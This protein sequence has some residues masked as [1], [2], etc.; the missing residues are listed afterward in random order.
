MSGKAF[1][2]EDYLI[3]GEENLIALQLQIQH[4]GI[5]HKNNLTLTTHMQKA[6]NS[7][8]VHFQTNKVTLKNK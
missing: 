2:G 4:L 1:R 5:K 6:D 7:N 8:S 3:A